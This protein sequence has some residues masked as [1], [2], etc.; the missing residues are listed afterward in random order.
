MT[1]ALA[2]SLLAQFGPLVTT[3]R[4][5]GVGPACATPCD[6]CRAASA[7]LHKIIREGEGKVAERLDEDGR[8]IIGDTFPAF[9][10]CKDHRGGAVLP[11]P[12][13]HSASATRQRD[14]SDRTRDRWS[15]PAFAAKYGGVCGWC[16][17]P[18]TAGSVIR[19]DG[20]DTLVGPCCLE[21]DDAEPAL[22]TVR[23]L[24]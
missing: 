1:E 19:Y 23:W 16:E 8:C 9:C 7:Q 14:R 12:D 11:E 15:S 13:D 6:D 3:C 4:V 17:V 2:R 24:S 10:G 5:L 22:S 20:D 21:S 18:F